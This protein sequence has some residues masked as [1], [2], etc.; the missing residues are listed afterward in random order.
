MQLPSLAVAVLL[1]SA[2]LS[3]ADTPRH[4]EES[5]DSSPHEFTLH[6]GGT[7]DGENTRDPVFY[8]AWKQGFEPMR[9][10]R[11]ENVGDADVVNPWVLVNGKRDWRTTANIVKDALGAYGDPQ[12]MTDAEKAQALWDFQRRHRFHATTGDLEVRD[13]VKLLNIYG[14]GLCGDSASVLA[15]LLRVSGF[16]TRRG[17]PIGHCVNEAWYGGAWHL[18]DADE[19]MIF[20]ARDNRT[21]ASEH[22]VARD[23][24]L[25]KRAQSDETLAALYSYDAAHGGDLP[26]HIAHTMNLTLRPGEALE[27]RWDSAGKYHRAPEPALYMVPTD[28][29]GWGEDAV[30]ALANGRWSYS[31]PLPKQP[32]PVTWKM[33]IP[34][35]IVGGRLKLRLHAG[36]YVFRI[37][38]DNNQ[39]TEAARVEAPSDMEAV[40]SL[41]EFFPNAGPAVYRYFLR[42]EWQGSGAGIDAVT[43]ENDL[44]MA[45]LSLPALELGDNRVRYFDESKSSR[46]VRLTL[47]WVE[48]NAPPPP[49][50]A[51]AIA[52]ADGAE[53]EGT[54][55][56]FRWRDGGKDVADYRFQLSEEPSM[57]FTLT[58]AFDAATSG[59]T[60]LLLPAEGLLNP[61]QRYY[62]R[63]RAKSSGGVWGE[64]SK[65]WSFVPQG[66]GAPQNVRLEADGP[67]AFVLRWNAS[68]AGRPATQFRI[69][70][71]N[72]KGFTVS[73]RA[74]RVATGALKNKGLFAGVESQVFPPNFLAGASGTEFKLR[75]QHAFYRVVA[76]DAKGN[77]SGPSDYAAGP[78]PFIYSEPATD[79]RIG[80]PYRYEAKAIASIGDLTDRVLGPGEP[81]QEGFWDADEPRFSLDA[82]M[83][84][85]GNFDPKWLH[86]DPHSGVVS[87]APGVGDAGEYL[88]NVKV[89]ISGV[90]TYI[91]SYALTVR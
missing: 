20:L 13:P 41:D 29:K 61:G 5:I 58:P 44:Q 83:P 54:Q 25:V 7:V 56:S 1:S 34:Y 2:A 69:Y 49:S 71:S 43:I 52:P 3:A 14:Y 57:R 12:R 8:A 31:P 48:R 47:D 90:G 33:E 30:A 50:P 27:W 77:R 73:D 66:P 6:L 91:Q 10:I 18:L 82:E 46:A 84:R 16:R 45:R 89:E 15:D 35:V 87:G 63:V 36:S 74:H 4:H 79:A 64:W 85:C 39:W 60:E 22:D 65:V 80:V 24:D 37:S 81:L 88:I 53:V 86:I 59:K 51:S 26:S 42:A 19:G 78:R 28:L 40:K 75:P 62:W 38:R 17:Y 21:I 70:A 11:L 32:D 23:H 9:F 68:S 67:D 55:V 72:E 76:I